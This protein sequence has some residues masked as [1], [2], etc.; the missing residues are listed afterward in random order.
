VDNHLEEKLKHLRQLTEEQMLA[1]IDKSF[2]CY[3]Y[4]PMRYVVT[5]GGKKLRPLLLLMVCEA[6]GESISHAL[7]AAA[8]IE[9]V[10]DFS[11]VHDD[12][13]D[14]D[15]LRRGRLTVHKKWDESVAILAGDGLL[16]YAFRA[17]SQ[18]PPEVVPRLLDMFSSSIIAVCEGQSLDKTFEQQDQV[19]LQEYKEMILLKTGKLF[20][21]SCEMGAVL[22]GGNQDQVVAMRS[23]GEHLGTVFQ[24]QDDL[25]DLTATEMNLGKDVGSDIKEGKKTWPVLHFIQ[26]ARPDQLQAFERLTNGHV[27]PDQILEI[28]ELFSKAGSIQAAE[29]SL[30]QELETLRNAL[31]IL[32]DNQASAALR[33]IVALI[34]KRDR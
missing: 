4:D 13:M 11:L 31:Q 10:H 21:L 23:F 25:L 3:L 22:A 17:L 8:A 5:A 27:G 14:H 20:G 29:Q 16:V 12:I 26:H 33:Q 32:P 7:P 24:I 6:L 9:M 30:R 34:E 15:D 18:C 19:S 2:P 1:I 28:V